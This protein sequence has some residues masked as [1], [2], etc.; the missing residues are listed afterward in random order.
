MT[1]SLV[2]VVQPHVPTELRFKTWFKANMTLGAFAIHRA[3]VS[4]WERYKGSHCAMC[5]ASSTP[6]LS[7]QLW[8]HMG[9]TE[10]VLKRQMPESQPQRFWF[11][12]S[13][14]GPGHQG[15]ESLRWFFHMQLRQR[16][17]MLYSTRPFLL[18]LWLIWCGVVLDSV[19]WA[20]WVILVNSRFG[21][22]TCSVVCRHITWNLFKM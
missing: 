21:G 6:E 12:W 3:L 20:F 7:F 9:I 10:E 17:S 5:W 1:E 4:R 13:W 11:N 22:N 8:L 18:R 15:L 19:L 16:T 14:I 2:S